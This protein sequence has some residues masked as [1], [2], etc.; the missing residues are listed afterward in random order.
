M[1]IAAVAPNERRKPG[2]K[3]V[4]GDQASASTAATPSTFNENPRRSR[5]RPAR[6][7]TATE[8]ARSTDGADPAIREYASRAT[9][10]IADAHSRGTRSSRS[11][12]RIIT[13]RIAMFPPEIAMT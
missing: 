12:T 3:I 13:A 10:V 6:R 2:S 9:I 7:M 8:M 1:R 11:V 4:T 5:T